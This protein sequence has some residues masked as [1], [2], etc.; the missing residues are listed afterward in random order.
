[1]VRLQSK[2]QHAAL[3]SRE[4]LRG[5]ASPRRPRS[6]STAPPR[7]QA[8]TQRSKR[9]ARPTARSSPSSRTR[10]PTTRGARSPRRRGAATSGAYFRDGAAR[11]DALERAAAARR[12][13]DRV[14]DERG[15]RVR[16]RPTILDCAESRHRRGVVST[17]DPRRTAA[18]RSRRPRATWPTARTCSTTTRASWSTVPRKSGAPAAGRVRPSSSVRRGVPLPLCASTRRRNHAG[19]ARR[20]VPGGRA[21]IVTPLELPA[22]PGGP[23][24]RRPSPRA[25]P[26]CSP[27]RPLVACS[28]STSSRRPG[29]SRRRALQ[30]A[31]GRPAAL[32]M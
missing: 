7:R 30:P 1:M 5:A 25:A 8:T 27:G 3:H 9:T 32:W 4:T 10:P 19:R 18:R 16:G 28:A 6:T 2:H 12:G 23:Q 14:R 17:P 15:A 31:H 13:R 24:G 11:R 21:A 20:D 29:R 22:A 26:S